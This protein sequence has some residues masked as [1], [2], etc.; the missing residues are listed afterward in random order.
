[1]LKG[2]SGTG[3]KP[4]PQG[5]VS[6]LSNL[7]MEVIRWRVDGLTSN[8]KTIHCVQEVWPTE[9][10]VILM[11]TSLKENGLNIGK[12]NNNSV[13]S[14]LLLIIFN[15]NTITTYYLISV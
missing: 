5:P 2:R 11:N 14:L 13:V 12:Y 10:R 9:H 3:G 8:L 4:V 15:I 6:C 7:P 1:M